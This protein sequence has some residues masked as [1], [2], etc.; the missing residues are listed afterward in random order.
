MFCCCWQ[1]KFV[2]DN[3]PAIPGHVVWLALSG[4][5][6]CERLVS[7]MTVDVLYLP[8][9]HKKMIHSSSS[10]WRRKR[11]GIGSC[12]LSGRHLQKRGRSL[13]S[14]SGI[15]SRW[16][17]NVKILP[18]CVRAIFEI[19]IGHH[20]CMRANPRRPW[21][22]A[23]RSALW[24]CRAFEFHTSRR[25]LF[26]PQHGFCV[27]FRLLLTTPSQVAPSPPLGST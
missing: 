27:I 3:D 26:C 5:R 18:A 20:C 13:L 21:K 8:A 4:L 2:G 14:R 10:S 17:E 1:A 24:P 25:Q 22:G 9:K 15:S 11:S 7:K 23:N 16:A 6:K 12:M 19:S